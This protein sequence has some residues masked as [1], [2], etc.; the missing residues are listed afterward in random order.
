MFKVEPTWDFFMDVIK[1]EYYLSWNYDD[2]YMRWTMMHQER[3]QTLK[4]F[5][6]TF[7]T[8]RTKMGI[9]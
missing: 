3:G 8:L 4:E 5:T 6:N 7:H 9:D 2:Q 1:K